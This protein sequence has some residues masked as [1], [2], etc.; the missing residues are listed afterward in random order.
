[1]YNNSKLL[2]LLISI[3][4][5]YDKKSNDDMLLQNHTDFL[6]Y[7]KKEYLN[8]NYNLLLHLYLLTLDKTNNDFNNY[9]FFGNEDTFTVF[10][11][12]KENEENEFIKTKITESLSNDTP[13]QI[14]NADI[15]YNAKTK[16]GRMQR[17]IS[18]YKG[19]FELIRFE[20]EKEKVSNYQNYHMNLCSKLRMNKVLYRDFK[21]L[22]VITEIKN[23]ETLKVKQYL[24]NPDNLENIEIAKEL[25]QQMEYDLEDYAVKGN[26]GKSLIVND[27][28]QNWISSFRNRHID[29]AFNKDVNNNKNIY[30]KI[31]T[32]SLN[33]ELY[34]FI[35]ELMEKSNIELGT[36]GRNK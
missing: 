1:M 11:F 19:V 6:N 5:G 12:N 14:D 15:I 2:L 16:T 4:E 22:N 8:I 24:S 7:L 36:R 18:L 17:R 30:D 3:I 29:I 9:Y 31:R 23:D 33:D 21:D 20:S 34:E 25:D 10:S 32:L 27:A 28:L 26:I 13:V 35:N